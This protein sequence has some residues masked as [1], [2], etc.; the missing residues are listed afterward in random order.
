[1]TQF[2]QGGGLHEAGPLAGIE[3]QFHPGFV[4]PALLTLHLQQL[5]DG[6]STAGAAAAIGQALQRR[7]PAPDPHL[8][9]IGSAHPGD[10]E[11]LGPGRQSRVHGL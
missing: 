10:A 2:M 9:L 8:G 3:Q 5:Q 6:A 4:L 7:A 11:Q 1:M